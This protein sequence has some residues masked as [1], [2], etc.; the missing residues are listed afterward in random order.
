M[1]AR[2]WPSSR[3]IWHKPS[4]RPYAYGN[5]LHGIHAAKQ[6]RAWGIDMD[7]HVTKDG[8]IVVTHWP[9]L[10]LRDAYRP[11]ASRLGRL[12]RVQ[13]MTLEQVH[14]LRSPWGR[15]LTAVEALNQTHKRGLR[16]CL[17]VKEDRAFETAT[18]YASLA[19]RCERLG[20]SPAL[21][22]VMTLSNLGSGDAPLRRLRAAKAAGFSTVLLAHSQVP[23]YW[24]LGASPIDYVRGP[25]ARWKA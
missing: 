25:R 12:R 14:Q 18:T 5:S 3:R 13:S 23:S 8:I 6:A 16:L 11:A 9:R 1:S 21:V 19:R 17:E 20:I 7:A 2:P 10:M 4:N 15:P 22:Y 24:T